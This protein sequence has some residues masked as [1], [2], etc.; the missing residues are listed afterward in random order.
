[1]ASIVNALRNISSDSWW[2]V[3]ITVMAL[4]V[5]FF[6]QHNDITNIDLASNIPIFTILG[7]IY[8][9]VAGV[10]MHRNI[11]NKSPLL[12]SLFS[13]P[14]LIMKSIGMSVVSLPLFF[15]YFFCMNY[16]YTNIVLEPFIMWVIYLCVTLFLAPFIFM[17]AV[18]YS[19]NGK[20]SDA[21]NVKIIVEGGGN[22]SVQFLSFMI[23]YIFTIFLLALLFYHL[24]INMIEDTTAVNVV[25]S[26]TVVIS[27]LTVYSYCSDMYNE[28]IP[29][30]PKKENK[31]KK[32]KKVNS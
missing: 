24:F 3:K 15:L 6:L 20:I 19:V 28:V 4:P 22:F 29:A 1:M 14:E 30:L 10:L 31:E 13:I 17:P 23:Q 26:Y 27:F 25:Y 21:F 2:A 18:L 5:F 16:I 32:T 12:P 7:V 8:L 9:G 11:K